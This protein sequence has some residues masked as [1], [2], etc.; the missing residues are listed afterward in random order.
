MP[1]I[2]VAVNLSHALVE[3]AMPAISAAV[4][5]SQAPVEAGHACD[6]GCGES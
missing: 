3:Q 4:N 6:L 2:S 1:A 5:L